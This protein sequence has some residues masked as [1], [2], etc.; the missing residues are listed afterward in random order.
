VALGGVGIEPLEAG[1]LVN[2][3]AFGLTI[4]AAGL[5]LRSNSGRSG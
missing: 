1:R 3:A 5:Y 4:L 2:A